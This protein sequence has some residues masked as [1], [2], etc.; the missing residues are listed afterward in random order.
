MGKKQERSCLVVL[1]NRG[2]GWAKRVL[3]TSMDGAARAGVCPP[4]NMALLSVHSSAK[5]LIHRL[6]YTELWLSDQ[7][8]RFC[9]IE[10][11]EDMTISNIMWRSSNITLAAA[12][13]SRS[14]EAR[15]RQNLIHLYKLVNN[16]G[17]FQ[18]QH[19]W[20]LSIQ[21]VNHEVAAIYLFRHYVRIF[22]WPQS[23]AHSE[24]VA[25]NW[26]LSVVMQ[27]DGNATQLS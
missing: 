18:M 19:I 15:W 11:P 16:V 1:K 8:C 3:E 27:V 21:L 22:K 4:G 26:R 10:R 17:I 5:R 25:Q 20:T 6:S 7:Y 23:Q 2:K 12:D 24:R 13:P 14:V 9:K